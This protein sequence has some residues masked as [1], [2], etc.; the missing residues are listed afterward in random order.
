M[1]F[2]RSS[3]F[4][5]RAVV[6]TTAAFAAGSVL[7]ATPAVAK[8]GSLTMVCSTPIGDQEFVTV[9][10]TNLPASATIGQSLPVVSEAVVTIPAALSELAYGLLGA[11]TVQGSAVVKTA[12]NDAAL[13][14]TNETIPSTT[15]PASGDLTVKATHAGPVFAP[16]AA[17]N[18]TVKLQSYTASII[19]KKADGS[20]AITVPTTCTPK[21]TVPVQDLTVSTVAV[22]APA[23]APAPAKQASKASAKVK[24]KGNEAVAK[25]KVKGVDGTAGSGKLKVV[26]KKGN[27][28]VKGVKSNAI[29]NGKGVAKS[30]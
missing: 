22:T 21:L 15:V 7:L 28:K 25:I 12:L 1:L 27:K 2:T 16:T 23:P 18:Y 26:L 8:S 6:G 11:G 30:S 3:S 5:K 9:A 29:L 13:P 17:G 24:V 10:D 19:F 14:D 20:E 4:R